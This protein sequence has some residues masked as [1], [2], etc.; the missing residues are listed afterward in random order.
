MKDIEGIFNQLIALKTRNMT[1]VMEIMTRGGSMMNRKGA[2][3]LPDEW[4]VFQFKK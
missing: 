3:E 4:E 1:S 2:T